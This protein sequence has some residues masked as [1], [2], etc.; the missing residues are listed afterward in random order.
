MEQD[1]DLAAYGARML[2]RLNMKVP[3]SDSGPADVMQV[4]VND[5]RVGYLG[6]SGAES[7]FQFQRQGC[8]D[9]IQLRSE[10]GA[11][12]GSLSAPECGFR[13]A[14]IPLPGGTVE[15]R[16]R[17]SAD[18][19]STSAVFTPVSGRRSWFLRAIAESTQAMVF[20]PTTAVTTS[21]LRAVIVMQIVLVAIVLGVVADRITAWMTSEHTPR[22]ATEIEVAKLEQQLGDLTRM[23]AEAVDSIQAQQRGIAQ[24]QSAVAKLSSFQSD[25]GSGMQVA[26]KN[27]K[28]AG[29][30]P[31][32]DRAHMSR[33]LI[34]QARVDQRQL[35]D[36]I[37]NLTEENARLSKEMAELAEQN[38][39]LEKMLKLASPEV[40][41]EPITGHDDSM[42]V[43]EPDSQQLT[44]T[45][46]RAEAEGHAQPFLFWVN[47]SEGTT[48]ES[49]DE[50][51]HDM[52]GHMVAVN[53]GWQEV[54]VTQPSMPTERFLERV[55]GAKIVKAVRVSR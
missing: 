11:V 43:Q 24:L 36:E 44:S 34:S 4:F 51:V 23:Q 10:D 14:R 3:R 54:E 7:T 38:Q 20:R 29:E 15:L 37:H 45:G 47:F 1:K 33:V 50:W 12:L 19:G 25:I 31:G 5:C 2:A 55:R 28:G 22:A 18:G 53:E 41:K 48:Q 39:D 35:E 26:R 9:H 17:N 40:S 8:V 46:P 30:D 21:G 32:Q 52:R 13:A 42:P 27:V 49:I 16:I 6:G